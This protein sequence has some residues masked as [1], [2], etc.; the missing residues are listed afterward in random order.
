[1]K[2][3][4]QIYNDITNKL[5]FQPE[6]QADNIAVSVNNGVV[7]LG[8][9]VS[10][11]SE[12][13]AT[14]RAVQKVRGVKGIA[15]EIKV[16]SSPQYKRND[17][18]IAK[19]AVNALEW[20][21]RVPH[22]NIKVLVEDGWLTLSGEVNWY[23]EKKCAELSVSALY[24]IK[25]VINQIEIKPNVSPVEVKNKIIEEFQRNALIDASGIQI[26][27]DGSV[28]ILKGSVSTWSESDAALEACWA[29]PGVSEVDN[30][31]EIEDIML[32]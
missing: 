4:K 1:M 14:E 11:Y 3:D 22:K 27:V 26:Q 9:A 7:T 15:N 30:Q 19:A 25:G 12:K 17:I 21:M 6:I 20:D 32:E 2:T 29:I 24:G 13:R 10:Q 16:E 28:V 31:L 23:H 5:S 18:D 8:G